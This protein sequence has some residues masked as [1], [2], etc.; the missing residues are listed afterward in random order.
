MACGRGTVYWQRRTEERQLRE[1]KLR[2]VVENVLFSSYRKCGII[3]LSVLDPFGWFP[4]CDILYQR[5]V[6]LSSLYGG[7]CQRKGYCWLVFLT[8]KPSKGSNGNKLCVFNFLWKHTASGCCVLRQH[9]F[10]TH[11]RQEQTWITV[12]LLFHLS[13]LS[14]QSPWRCT[15]EERLFVWSSDSFYLFNPSPVVCLFH[16]LCLFTSSCVT[17]TS[18]CLSLTHTDSHK[19]SCCKI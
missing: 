3:S 16:P 6:F 7:V 18:C 9:C 1:T 5:L 10:H 13:T 8:T 11:R 12:L 19:H 17:Y 14:P 4:L 15:A 2:H